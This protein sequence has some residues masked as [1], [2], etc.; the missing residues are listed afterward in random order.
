MIYLYEPLF[1]STKELILSIKSKIK[2]L[3][4]QGTAISLTLI[5]GVID[6]KALVKL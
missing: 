4:Y 2:A 3:Q 6:E 5:K 1:N